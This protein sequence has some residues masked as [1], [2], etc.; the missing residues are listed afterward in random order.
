MAS[1]QINVKVRCSG[2]TKE[3]TFENVEEDGAFEPKNEINEPKVYWVYDLHTN[4]HRRFTWSN[5]CLCIPNQRLSRCEAKLALLHLKHIHLSFSNV[6]TAN[7]NVRCLVSLFSLF[8]VEANLNTFLLLFNFLF[9]ETY[10]MFSEHDATVIYLTATHSLCIC[11]K[12]KPLRTHFTH[13]AWCSMNKIFSSKADIHCYEWHFCVIICFQICL[14]IGF[15]GTN[16]PENRENI[17]ISDRLVEEML[18]KKVLNWNDMK[19]HPWAMIHDPWSMLDVTSPVMGSKMRFYF[20]HSFVAAKKT[21]VKFLSASC[22]M[23]HDGWII[24]V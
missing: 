18:S 11:W 9:N 3:N 2:G 23:P 10:R 24:V 17:K 12:I 19:F 14:W 20:I 1:Q 4:T 7:P 6:F 16:W 8:H 15:D 13:E 22:L 21:S 5:G